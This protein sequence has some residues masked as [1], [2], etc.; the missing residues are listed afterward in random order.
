MGPRYVE[1]ALQIMW[2]TQS[3][4]MSQSQRVEFRRSSQ[5]STPLAPSH[6]S[7]WAGA[8]ASSN[9]APRSTTSVKDTRDRCPSIATD[10]V[11]CEK[12]IHSGEG[13]G[14][15]TGRTKVHLRNAN[16]TGTQE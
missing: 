3:L 4:T 12:E 8:A 1:L 13:G 14:G 15:E 7:A 2:T 10:R 16:Y 9:T 11:V 5:R 6:D